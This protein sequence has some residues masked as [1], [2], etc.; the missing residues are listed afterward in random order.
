[1][2]YNLGLNSKD[3]NKA[4]CDYLYQRF[5]EYKNIGGE[6][7]LEIEFS[8]DELML[9]VPSK[10]YIGIT[11]EFYKGYSSD[12]KDA[13]IINITT[14]QNDEKL[15]RYLEEYVENNLIFA[16]GKPLYSERRE[17]E[18]SKWQKTL[19]RVPASKDKKLISIIKE[20]SI[21]ASRLKNTFFEY[22]VRPL[23]FFLIHEKKL[24]IQ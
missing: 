3:K 13:L 23:L 20:E 5:G 18:L 11:P 17:K 14:S 6:R 1:M 15:S 2:S 7:F 21:S 19:E 12:K 10:N 9:S 24:F 4:L 22:M 16:K 8:K